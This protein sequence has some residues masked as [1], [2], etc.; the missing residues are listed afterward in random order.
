M[1]NHTERRPPWDTLLAELERQALPQR[2]LARSAGISPGYLNDLIRGRRRVTGR[3]L[4][5]VADSL[6]VPTEQIMPAEPAQA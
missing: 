1:D 3:V 2:H 6:G 5:A 4:R